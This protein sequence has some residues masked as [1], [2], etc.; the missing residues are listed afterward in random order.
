MLNPIILADGVFDPFHDRHVDYLLKAGRVCPDYELVVQV[1]PQTKRIEWLSQHYRAHVVRSVKGVARTVTCR[2][3]LEA[4]QA[5]RPSY[6]VKGADWRAKGIPEAEAAWCSSEGVEVV[7]VQTNGTLSSTA[8]LADYAHRQAAQG[9]DLFDVDAQVQEVVPFDAETQGYGDFEARQRIEGRHPDILAKL[10]AGKSVLDVGCGAGYLVR[11][12]RERKV[13][14]WGIDP[15]VLSSPWVEMVSVD[16]CLGDSADLAIC[17]EVLEHI[18]V[19]EWGAFLF[20]LFRVAH[21]R[22]YITTRFTAAPAHPYDL[23]TE[24]LADPSHITL[25]PQ[26]FLRALCVTM[27]GTRDR[28]WE[29][30][31]DWQEQRRVLVY[32]KVGVR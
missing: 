1:S 12:L 32:K 7:Y 25:L 19:R 3:T 6:Y 26:P 18:P 20:H 14:A 11:M 4:L 9:V 22:V 23:T 30:A 15:Y 24:F 17:R 2:T 5:L 13:E 16:D 27:G 21:E 29:T 28:D 31:L 8:L 10:C